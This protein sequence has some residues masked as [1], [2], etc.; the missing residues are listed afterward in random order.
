MAI[1]L[2]SPAARALSGTG[3]T[4][5]QHRLTTPAGKRDATQKRRTVRKI[6]VDTMNGNP[7][8]RMTDYELTRFARRV[9]N[10]GEP[11]FETDQSLRH[12][13]PGSYVGVGGNDERKRTL[14]QVN[15]LT[16]CI[17][18]PSPICLAK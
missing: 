6:Q 18:P 16:A 7:D 9:M 8:F 1:Y 10:R 14:N 4:G 5:N 3:E 15:A 12:G 13:L 11:L 17:R 2:L